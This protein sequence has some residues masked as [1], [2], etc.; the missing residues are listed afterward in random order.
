LQRQEANNGMSYTTQAVVMSAVP[1]KQPSMGVLNQHRQ[2]ITVKAPP[3]ST[4]IG[5]SHEI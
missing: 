3:T 4:K 2:A 1:I 5:F